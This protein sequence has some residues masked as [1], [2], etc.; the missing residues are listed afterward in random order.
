M[1]SGGSGL[2]RTTKQSGCI[3]QAYDHLIQSVFPP[4]K[5]LARNA[6]LIS[7]AA[8]EYADSQ[9]DC[10]FIPAPPGQAAATD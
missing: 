7:N 2:C 9:C 8:Q 6:Y 4:P 1:N 5:V 10:F 3:L